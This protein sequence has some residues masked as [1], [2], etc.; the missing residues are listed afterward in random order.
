MTEFQRVVFWA[1]SLILWSIADP[2]NPYLKASCK[3]LAERLDINIGFD[4]IL[5]AEDF[6]EK[7]TEV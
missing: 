5:E 1:L 3:D 6:H 4:S 7:N 2:K